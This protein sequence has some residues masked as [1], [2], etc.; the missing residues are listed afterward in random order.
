MRIRYNLP[1]AVLLG[2]MAVAAPAFGEHMQ[3]GNTFVTTPNCLILCE[4]PRGTD[5]MVHA[6]FM[7]ATISTNNYALYQS[8][9]PWCSANSNNKVLASGLVVDANGEIPGTAAGYSD[10]D[11]VF[12]GDFTLH[13]DV[14]ATIP[15]TSSRRSYDVCFANGEGFTSFPV[16]LT[17]K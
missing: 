9:G 8:V 15:S 14:R 12:D 3:N 16:I 1:L 11:L 7:S 17:V 2:I 13:T 4:A 5:I 6:R 10:Q